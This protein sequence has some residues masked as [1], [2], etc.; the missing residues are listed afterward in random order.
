MF[1]RT[2]QFLNVALL[3]LMSSLDT[4]ME[5]RVSRHVDSVLSA[6]LDTLVSERVRMAVAAAMTDA[7]AA[8]SRERVKKVKSERRFVAW[9]GI[10][11]VL[12]AVGG[13]FVFWNLPEAERTKEGIGYL[14]YLFPL[15]AVLVAGRGLIITSEKADAEAEA[16]LAFKD[17]LLFVGAGV[18]A[19]VGYQLGKN[20]YTVF[21][22]LSIVLAMMLWSFAR[23][24]WVL[25]RDARLSLALAALAV[26]FVLGSVG[27][28]WWF[29]VEQFPQQW[30]DV[31]H[32]G[33]QFKTWFDQPK[34]EKQN[35]KR[36]YCT[37]SK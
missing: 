30:H 24:V 18:V 31:F 25:V 20:P 5:A 1:D 28:I 17:S 35:V 4:E 26:V 8:R 29:S 9:L 33:F 15:F 6:R 10:L 27:S 21:F 16:S 34:V 12:L 23:H 3:R 2:K 32:A 7:E 36:P 37:D 11:S 22:A 19:Q 14:A 13:I